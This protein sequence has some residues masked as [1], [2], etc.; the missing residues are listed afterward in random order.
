MKYSITLDWLFAVN[1]VGSPIIEYEIEIWDV[2]TGVWKFH[3]TSPAVD[4]GHNCAC[5]HTLASTTYIVT[6]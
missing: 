3:G 1:N 4:I 5:P 2:V 6:L